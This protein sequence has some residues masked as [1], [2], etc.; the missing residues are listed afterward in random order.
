[1]PTVLPTKNLRQTNCWQPNNFD[2]QYDKKEPEFRFFFFARLLPGKRNIFTAVGRKGVIQLSPLKGNIAFRKRL[3][4][5]ER[6]ILIKYHILSFDCGAFSL[7][8]LE[9]CIMLDILV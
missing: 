5:K 9:I 4:E 6:E 8:A 7:A 1:M 3:D 2:S